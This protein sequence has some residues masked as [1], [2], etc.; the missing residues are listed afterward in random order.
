MKKRKTKSN[1]D[2]PIC[3]HNRRVI[4]RAVKKFVIGKGLTARQLQCEVYVCNF[5]FFVIDPS[6][7]FID[8]FNKEY[9]RREKI[10]KENNLEK[11]D[12]MDEEGRDQSGRASSQD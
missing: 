1:P 6:E 11:T 10:R 2:C 8:K 4:F 7:T 9:N 5:C 12:R 3:K